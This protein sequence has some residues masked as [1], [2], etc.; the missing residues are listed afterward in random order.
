MLATVFNGKEKLLDLRK[1]V[2]LDKQGR[3]LL[4]LREQSRTYYPSLTS[5]QGLCWE[6]L[7]DLRSP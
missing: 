6:L 2:T 7:H 3:L 1:N 4:E 5:P